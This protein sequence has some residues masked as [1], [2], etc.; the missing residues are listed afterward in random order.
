MNKDAIIM[1]V[2]QIAVSLV[3]AVLIYLVAFVFVKTQRNVKTEVTADLCEETTEQPKAFV[4]GYIEPIKI[5]TEAVTEAQTEAE[6]ETEAETAEIAPET[7]ETYETEQIYPAETEAV[8][9]QNNAPDGYL[10]NFYI[11]GYT[12]EEGFYEGKTTASGVGVG[13]GQVAMNR[14]R[15]RELGIF[16]GNKIAI[17]GMGTYT[18]TDCGCSYNTVDVW[19]LTNAE[20]YAITGYYNVYKVG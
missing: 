11:T 20:A 18:V 9:T 3:L 16:Y 19:V 13:S 6:T 1:R 12:A 17:E 5:E 10:G 2:L 8:T 4:A 14:Q 15:M 7:C